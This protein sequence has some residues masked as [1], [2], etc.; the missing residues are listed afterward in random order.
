MS[1][2]RCEKLQGTTLSLSL[3][4]VMGANA[5]F[6]LLEVIMFLGSSE[7]KVVLSQL[8]NMWKQRDRTS[9]SRVL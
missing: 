4:F 6:F 8:G 7:N 5:E 9:R 3:S 1:T 2:I